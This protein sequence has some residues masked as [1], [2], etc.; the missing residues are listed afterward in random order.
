MKKTHDKQTEQLDKIDEKWAEKNVK[1]RANTATF[2]I[3]PPAS[4]RI[5]DEF[6]TQVKII[7]INSLSAVVLL[8]IVVVC[9]PATAGEEREGK[10]KL[11]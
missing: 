6:I 1:N 4:S 5:H 2:F 10:G 8:I 3:C 7:K 11:R 9:S